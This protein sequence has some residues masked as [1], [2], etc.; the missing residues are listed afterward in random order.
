M[1]QLSSFDCVLSVVSHFFHTSYCRPHI[2]Y[3]FER[4]YFVLHEI[5]KEN[6]NFHEICDQLLVSCISFIVESFNSSDF[7]SIQREFFRCKRRD[8][9]LQLNFHGFIGIRISKSVVAC[10][11][12]NAS[13]VSSIIKVTDTNH[14]R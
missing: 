3:R 4:T 11:T 9:I 12:P 13:L 2:L 8:R 10:G 6:N 7:H 14:Q 5:L 1:S